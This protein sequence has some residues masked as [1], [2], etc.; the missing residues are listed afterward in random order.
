MYMWGGIAA[1]VILVIV[2]TIILIVTLG[3]EDEKPKVTPRPPEF[4][5]VQAEAVDISFETFKDQYMS[6]TV[7]IKTVGD[8]TWLEVTLTQKCALNNYQRCSY[9]VNKFYNFFIL[10]D[11]AEVDGKTLNEALSKKEPTMYS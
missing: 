8:G 6:Q 9:E 3:G 4:I 7:D 11:M 5:D 10:T 2:V 1:A